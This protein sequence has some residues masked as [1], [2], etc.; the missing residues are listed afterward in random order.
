MEK[1]E[2]PTKIVFHC[3]EGDSVLADYCN[4]K[5]F[6]ISFTGIITFKKADDVRKI[7][8]EYPDDRIMAETDAPFLSPVPFR[9]KRND[10]SKIKYI[11]EKI[12]EVKGGNLEG[13]KEKIFFNSK[14]FFNIL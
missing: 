5:G 1:E 9:G 8:S 11:V 6:Y 14:K 2:L 4:K 12:S 7:C 10:P 13:W 3:F